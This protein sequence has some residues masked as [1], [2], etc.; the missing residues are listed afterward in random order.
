VFVIANFCSAIQKHNFTHSFPIL[1]TSAVCADSGTTDPQ[2]Y[3]AQQT[4]HLTEFD[5]C[6]V[7]RWIKQI[8]IWDDHF[9]VELKSRLKI[10]I[11]G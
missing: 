7:R 5:E 11:E 1:I 2:D 6:L 4:T 10:D 3:I 8:T 9:T